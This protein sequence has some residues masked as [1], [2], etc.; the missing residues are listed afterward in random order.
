MEPCNDCGVIPLSDDNFKYLDEYGYGVCLSC[1]K[2]YSPCPY[3]EKICHEDEFIYGDLCPDCK[4]TP[5]L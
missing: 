2:D 4:E 5:W 3:C 1:F